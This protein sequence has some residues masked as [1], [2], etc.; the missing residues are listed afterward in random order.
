MSFSL[1]E[2]S[3]LRDTRCHAVDTV[4][5]LRWS[6]ARNAVSEES[7]VL[8]LI[9][10]PIVVSKVARTRGIRSSQAGRSI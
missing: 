2:C 7:I 10:R 6:M 4:L 3:V 5:A 8:S 9:R 1:G